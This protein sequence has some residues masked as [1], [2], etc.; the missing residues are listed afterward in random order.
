[1]SLEGQNKIQLGLKYPWDK[2]TSH[3]FW[4][5]LTNF[6]VEKNCGKLFINCL[7]QILG[8]KKKESININTQYTHI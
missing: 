2:I 4:A 5:L 8:Q 3:S 1:M 7:R 6:L